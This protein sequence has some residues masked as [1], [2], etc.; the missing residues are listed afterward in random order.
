MC[1][2]QTHRCEVNP[3]CVTCGS[4][5][6]W[7]TQESVFQRPLVERLSLLDYSTHPSLSLQS[8][9]H[10]RSHG[11]TDTERF[12][13]E[14]IYAGIFCSDICLGALL[15]KELKWEGPA[16][17]TDK[18]KPLKKTP[19]R[20][21]M[22]SAMSFSPLSRHKFRLSSSHRAAISKYSI[23]THYSSAFSIMLL[24]AAAVTPSAGSLRH[25]MAYSLDLCCVF[26]LFLCLY[27]FSG[28]VSHKSRSERSR[29][30]QSDAGLHLPKTEM[31][32]PFRPGRVLERSVSR[33]RSREDS[34]ERLER[35]GEYG[36]IRNDRIAGF[37]VLTRW[38]FLLVSKLQPE[39]ESSW[40]P[41]SNIPPT[42]PTLRQM[43]QP[44][45]SST[46][47][48]SGIQSGSYS[49]VRHIR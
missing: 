20:H 2:P 43:C 29:K 4:A 13:P 40:T 23:P 11:H 5:W 41:Q 7:P 47:L 46:P 38:C 42:T 21:K 9:T 31:L 12:R 24:I 39:S 30:H 8:G 18:L 45:D 44:S 26:S 14:F 33:K 35:E 27:P 16:R 25:C 1:S 10:T 3:A 32:T 34:Y 36:W 15:Q 22:S 37:L 49:V 48:T 19:I 28:L 17:H 6:R